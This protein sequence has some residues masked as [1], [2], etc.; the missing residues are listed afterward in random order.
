MLASANRFQYRIDTGRIEVL[1]LDYRR[2]GKVIDRARTRIAT[3]DGKRPHQTPKADAE[4]VG[5]AAQLRSKGLS[6]HVLCDDEAV[7]KVVKAQFPHVRRLYA[8]QL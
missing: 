7:R 2:Y 8:R 5:A 3:L 1:A 6:F 4:I